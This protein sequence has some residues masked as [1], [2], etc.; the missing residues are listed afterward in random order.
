MGSA[1]GR[2]RAKPAA[3]EVSGGG[4]GIT[5]CPTTTEVEVAAAAE[6]AAGSKAEVSAVGTK[7]AMTQTDKVVA[8][9]G[10]ME[11]NKRPKTQLSQ[12][13]EPEEEV[14]GDGITEAEAK[15]V[16]ADAAGTEQEGKPMAK[17]ATAA[18]KK[19]KKK[20]PATATRLDK[21]IIDINLPPASPPYA[22]MSDEQHVVGGLEQEQSCLGQIRGQEAGCIAYLAG[23]GDQ[24]ME[25]FG[26]DEEEER[27]ALAN[28]QPSE[29]LKELGF[30]D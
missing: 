26:S 19:T 9:P 25:S 13:P 20:T 5:K 24:N 27:G 23:F 30:D 4:V 28:W 1:L 2:A 10:S 15:Q 18:G 16:V 21:K 17:P 29:V 6:A 22:C 12:E 11:G 8:L 3:A 7:R 14:A